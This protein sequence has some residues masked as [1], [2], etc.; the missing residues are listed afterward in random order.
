MRCEPLLDWAYRAAVSL[1]EVSHL[2]GGVKRNK[3][4]ILRIGPTRVGAEVETVRKAGPNSNSLNR[5]P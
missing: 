5:A 2:T 4:S 1:V 3:G